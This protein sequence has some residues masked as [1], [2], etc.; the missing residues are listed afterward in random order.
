MHG[1]RIIGVISALIAC[2]AGVAQ[3]PGTKRA[4]A[5]EGARLITG[6]G[7]VIERA[8]FLVYDGRF[9]DV[10]EQGAIEIPAN[11]R[12]VDL[13]GKTVMPALVDVHTHLGYRTGA[14]FA[15]EN[16]TREKIVDELNR[17]ACYGVAAVASA[18]T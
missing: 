10:G 8:A 5:F 7:R 2:A 17:L 6:D 9:S 14:A 4:V 16:F 13:R 1:G 12:R 15:A 11:I 18:G 3:A